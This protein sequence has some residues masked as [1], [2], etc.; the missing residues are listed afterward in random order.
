M[1]FSLF[2]GIRLGIGI[3]LGFLVVEMTIGFIGELLTY[4]FAK[5]SPI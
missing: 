5:G 3:A 1:N 4:L 2:Q